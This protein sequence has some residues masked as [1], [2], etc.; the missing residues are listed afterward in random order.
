MI[1]KHYEKKERENDSETQ[2]NEFLQ[3]KDKR[4]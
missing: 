4:K 1:W 3:K 2:Q